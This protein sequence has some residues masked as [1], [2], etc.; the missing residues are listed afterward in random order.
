MILIKDFEEKYIDDVWEIEKTCFSSPW[1]REDLSAQLENETSHFY[2]AVCDGKVSGYMG[3][4]IF[5]KEGYVTNVAVLPQFRRKGV[6]KALLER[7]MQNEMDFIT[8]EV[9][10]S[11]SPA[12]SLYKNAG[13]IDVGIRPHFYSNPNEDAVI[14]T[15][16]KEKI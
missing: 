11:N 7:A 10:K 8:L 15:R 1:S 4:Q 14:M 13:F 16:F 9:R 6:A 5:S 3:L 12:I 2:V